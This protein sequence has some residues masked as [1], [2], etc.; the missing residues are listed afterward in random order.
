MPKIQQIVKD[1]F[2]KE[3]HKGATGR[4]GRDLELRRRRACW[5]A[6]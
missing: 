1:L 2:G 6:K 5:G 3:P 4:S